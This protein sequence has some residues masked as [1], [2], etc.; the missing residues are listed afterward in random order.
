VDYRHL[1][2]I[3]VK[4]KFSVPIIDEFLDE[5]K[6]VGLAPAAVDGCES[7]ACFCARQEG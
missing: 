3:I 6:L 5:Y 7:G 2:P 1:S 4:G